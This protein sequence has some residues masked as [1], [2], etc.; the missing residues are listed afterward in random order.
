MPSAVGHGQSVPRVTAARGGR[1]LQ[2]PHQLLTAIAA[3]MAI[4]GVILHKWRDFADG[5]QMNVQSRCWTRCCL[6][7]SSV[8]LFWCFCFL[9][10]QVARFDL[11]HLRPHSVSS[12][13]ITIITT[14]KCQ[15]HQCYQSILRLKSGLAPEAQ[16]QAPLLQLR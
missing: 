7:T 2:S 14:I 15:R 10:K 16:A 8:V 1:L 9:R 5:N 6:V 11:R 4:S 12:H 13:P 3:F